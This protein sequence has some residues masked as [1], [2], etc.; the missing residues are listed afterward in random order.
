M[1]SRFRASVTPPERATSKCPGP[2]VRGVTAGARDSRSPLPHGRPGSVS[3]SVVPCGP[4]TSRG[5]RPQ[6]R[7]H[8]VRM[9]GCQ[10]KHRNRQPLKITLRSRPASRS[11]RLVRAAAAANLLTA[12]AKPDI[13]CA[14]EINTPSVSFGSGSG[15][16]VSPVG[17]CDEDDPNPAA[18]SSSPTPPTSTSPSSPTGPPIA[19]RRSPSSSDKPD[20]GS[21]RPL[22]HHS[23]RQRGAAMLA[24]TVTS[25]SPSACGAAETCPAI[26]H[27]PSA[28]GRGADS[29]RLSVVQLPET[30]TTRTW[31][32]IRHAP[33]W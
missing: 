13:T 31:S 26:G 19:P 22:P 21:R 1:Q 18:S 2:S 33:C 28:V 30:R 8:T 12:Q 16:V 27:R 10:Q 9:P 14:M 23:V 5:R 17:Q 6:S 11:A 4:S 32:T 29:T 25:T 15:G 3:T 7:M 20:C 24:G